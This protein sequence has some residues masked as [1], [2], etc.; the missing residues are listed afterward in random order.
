MVLRAAVGHL[1]RSRPGVDLPAQML[2]FAGTMSR[3]F[4]AN[5]LWSAVG[6]FTC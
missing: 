6:Q 2:P 4:D 1:G 3:M 5:R